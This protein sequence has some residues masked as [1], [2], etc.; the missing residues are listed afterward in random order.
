MKNDVKVKSLKKSLI[1]CAAVMSLAFVLSAGAVFPNT[2]ITPL[3]ESTSITANAAIPTGTN[4][5][6]GM[7]NN[8]VLYLQYGL[9][10]FGYYTHGCTGYFD[11]NTESALKAFQSANDL[12]PDG[13]AGY[14]TL[15]ALNNKGL[16][17]QDKLCRA[18]YYCTKDSIP[19]PATRKQI[20][21]F[22]KNH[23]ISGDIA[24][25]ST[26]NALNNSLNYATPLVNG[27]V[28]RITPQC[29][30]NSCV[31]ES[32]VSNKI[33]GN[34]HLWQY[35]GNKNQL[36]VAEYVGNGYYRFKNLNS[37]LYLDKSGGGNQPSNVIQ[38]TKN[39]TYA[40]NWKLK[41]CGNGWYSI[42][43]QAENQYL[44]V[45][46]CRNSNGTQ[47]QTYWNT[48]CSAQRF[49]FE[50]VNVSNNKLNKYAVLNYANTY[51]SQRNYNYN[52]YNNNNC[53]NY[54]SQ[55]LVAG[56]LP[57]NS[58]FCNGTSAFIYVPTFV[59]YMKNNYNVQYISRPSASQI[60]VGDVLL[61]A[62]D[63][64]MIVTRKENGTI[65][66]NGNTNNRYQL[67]ISSSY[68]YAVLKTSEL[69]N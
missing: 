65:F 16:E 2:L 29:A 8:S 50:K 68:F 48:N 63:H 54:V 26:M 60:E 1:K 24:T 59:S 43:N 4:L 25:N 22:N 34:V 39:G 21:E 38:Y 66:A 18:G 20:G 35:Y 55:C 37:G 17:L 52:Y 14:Y 27:A 64:V 41:S 61:T 69:M 12:D 47:I 51:W 40:Q 6:R 15:T 7:S 49:K 46:C 11:A 45:N 28:Y 58:T 56:G 5:R 36:W 10:T 31:D 57:T 44:D 30:T 67:A 9:T 3:T 33:G 32:T 62:S 19:G 13:I 23:N 42:V 53:C